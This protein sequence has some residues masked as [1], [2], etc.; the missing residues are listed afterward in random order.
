M[1]SLLRSLKLT[2][3]LLRDAL[4]MVK[5]DSSQPETDRRSVSIHMPAPVPCKSRCRNQRSGGVLAAGEGGGVAAA[6]R[7]QQGGSEF[8]GCGTAGWGSAAGGGG[9]D[10]IPRQPL[11]RIR[12]RQRVSGACLT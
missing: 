3:V 5:D 12:S 1:N 8:Y 10:L 2:G 9:R 11:W 7:W 6:W 4:P